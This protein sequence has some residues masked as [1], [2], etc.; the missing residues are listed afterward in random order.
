[1]PHMPWFIYFAV[2]Y[3]VLLVCQMGWINL[4]QRRAIARWLSARGETPLRLS[5]EKGFG[6]QTYDVDARKMD[7]SEAHYCLGIDQAFLT[8]KVREV[9]EMRVHY[10][11]SRD[12]AD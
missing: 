9:M 3:W 1:M 11:P 8:G 5:K 6:I 4:Q 2:S 12:K 7:G 10:H